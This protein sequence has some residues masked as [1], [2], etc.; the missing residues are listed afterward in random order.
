M[1]IQTKAVGAISVPICFPSIF[2]KLCLSISFCFSWPITFQ[3]TCISV[4]AIHEI[5]IGWSWQTEVGGGR[6]CKE[7]RVLESEIKLKLSPWQLENPHYKFQIFKHLGF[8]LSCFLKASHVS[9]TTLMGKNCKTERE[10]EGK[11][12][13]YT[14][15]AFE[16]K[17][18]NILSVICFASCCLFC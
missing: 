4:P 13:R 5:V 15:V 14:E 8:V 3:K 9:M 1:E 10:N 17:P 16:I 18:T 12:Q 11:F 6:K 7:K 2:S